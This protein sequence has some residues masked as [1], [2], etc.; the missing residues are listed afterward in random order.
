MD[1]YFRESR[2][3][4]L[5]ILYYVETSIAANWSNVT[6]VKRFL[7]A[8]KS[9]LP[10]I[11]IN[12]STTDNNYKEVGT[13][14]LYNDYIISIDI[15]AK[16][17]GQRL[18]LADFIMDKLKDGC[19]YYTHSQTS[20]SPETLTRVAGGYI[21]VSRFSMNSRIDFGEED[22]VDVYDRFRHFIEIAVRKN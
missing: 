9:S 2:N 8:Y 17:D 18:D 22:G 16:S 4:E 6:V 20:G 7:D 11:A 5:S 3:I 19:T 14:S 15:F 10:V 13:T 21:H 12:L 1:S